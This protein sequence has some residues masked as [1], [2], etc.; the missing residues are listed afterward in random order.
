MNTVNNVNEVL[1]RI[2]VK[3]YQNYLSDVSGAYFAR[4]NN[5][6]ALSIEEVCAAAKNRGGYTGKY[7]DLVR[8]VKV[9]FDEAA[10]QLADGFA[11]NTGWFSLYPKIGG[12]FSNA[13]ESPD[14]KKHRVSFAFRPLDRLRELAERIVVEVEGIAD[15]LGFINEV[16]DVRS[17]A[18]NRV[19]SPGG[20]M[21]ITGTKIKVLGDQPDVGIWF[22]QN[23]PNTNPVKVTENLSE[24]S[25]VKIIAPIPSLKKG[26]NWRLR[27]VTQYTSGTSLLKKSR[28]IEY[29][30]EFIVA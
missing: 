13:G 22:Y 17:G 28:V 30:A 7:E 5:E 4:T 15:P 29:P 2:K 14:S 27:I 8:D 20:A 3:L 23:T 16:L 1:H 24:N 9:F 26:S 19:L 12:T 21:V 11:V 25:S 18:V 6:A 10:Y